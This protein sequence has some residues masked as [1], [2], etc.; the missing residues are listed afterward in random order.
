MD[1]TERVDVESLGEA[2]VGTYRA[3]NGRV[4]IVTTES[5]TRSEAMDAAVRWVKS[6]AEADGYV[7]EE[8]R[9]HPGRFEVFRAGRLGRKPVPLEPV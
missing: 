6:G 9:R 8:S 1:A 3:P 2:W 7:W 5:P 4:A